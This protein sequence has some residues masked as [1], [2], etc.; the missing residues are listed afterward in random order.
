MTVAHSRTIIAAGLMIAFF[1]GALL[2]PA[3]P[4]MGQV[5]IDMPP[6]PRA[7][8]DSA[9]SADTVDEADAQPTEDEAAED[10]EDAQADKSNETSP[11]EEA[12]QTAAQHTPVMRSRYTRHRGDDGLERLALNR[13]VG[14]RQYSR[15][16]HSHLHVEYQPR[17]RGVGPWGLGHHCAWYGG[18]YTIAPTVFISGRGERLFR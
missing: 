5:V 8:V 3:R 4:A 13:Y 17:G 2:L 9:D 15:P 6:P 7:T 18:H 10:A 1:L 11:S 14:A 12:N 16:N